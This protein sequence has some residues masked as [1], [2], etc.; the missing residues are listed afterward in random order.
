MTTCA[1]PSSPN[2]PE[3]D[4]CIVSDGTSKV[5]PGANRRKVSFKSKNIERS[6]LEMY[7]MYEA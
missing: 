2:K 4:A 6:D 3:E 7:R 5:D 1:V